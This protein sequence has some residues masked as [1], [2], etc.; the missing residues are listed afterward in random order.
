[1]RLRKQRNI[2]VLIVFYFYF[3]CAYVQEV[4]IR[5]ETQGETQ[6]HLEELKRDG[7]KQ[8]ARL[9]EEKEKLQNEFEEMKYSGEAKLS[10][11]SSLPLRYF[12]CRRNVYGRW[13]K[14]QSRLINVLR[15]DPSGSHFVYSLFLGVLSLFV[16]YRTT[17]LS[18][19]PS[20]SFL[21]AN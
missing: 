19:F 9:R 1:M 16:F 10:R 5:F 13:G 17:F 8:I 11:Y 14:I 12:L 21:C 4:V 18:R 6:E 7:E 3:L 20:N 15:R 2:D